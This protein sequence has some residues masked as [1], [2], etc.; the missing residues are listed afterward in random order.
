MWPFVQCGQQIGASKG[1]WVEES[2]NQLLPNYPFMHG[3]AAKAGASP[4]QTVLLNSS[5][6]SRLRSRLI[7]KL[8]IGIRIEG[9]TDF[10]F[11][12]P[13]IFSL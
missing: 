9:G 5:Q 13:D 6:F 1:L 7:P 3:G 8:P 4:Q 11:L 2:L 10:L 12:E